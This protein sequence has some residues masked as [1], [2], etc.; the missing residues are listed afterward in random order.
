MGGKEAKEGGDMCKHIA[1]SHSYMAEI[2]TIS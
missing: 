2:N 1:D